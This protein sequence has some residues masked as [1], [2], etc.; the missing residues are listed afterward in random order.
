MW[1][2]CIGLQTAVDS[3]RAAEEALQEEGYNPK[4]DKQISRNVR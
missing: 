3:I 4:V 1:V 2:M